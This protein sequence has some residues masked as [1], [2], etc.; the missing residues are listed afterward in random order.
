MEASDEVTDSSNEDGDD[1]ES[2]G[3]SKKKVILNKIV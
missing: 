1:N 2:D 3:E